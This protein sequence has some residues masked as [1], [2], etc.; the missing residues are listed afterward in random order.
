MK[1]KSLSSGKVHLNIYNFKYLYFNSLKRIRS[2]TTIISY[3]IAIMFLRYLLIICLFFIPEACGPSEDE[4]WQ[5]TKNNNTTEAYEEFLGNFPTSKHTKEIKTI[6]DSL[7]FKYARN[8]NTREAYEEYLVKYPNG[9]FHTE[10]RNKLDQIELMEFNK[11]KQENTKIAFENYLRIYPKGKFSSE[12][13]NCIH[14]Y[15]PTIRVIIKESYKNLNV[16]NLLP[17]VEICKNYLEPL[18]FQISLN[19]NDKIDAVLTVEVEGEP[20]DYDGIYL[21]AKV[22]GKIIYKYS[23]STEKYT[24][25]FHGQ[26]APYS[27]ARYSEMMKKPENAPFKLALIRGDLSRVHE[28]SFYCRLLQLVANVWGTSRLLPLLEDV[29]I[30]TRSVAITTLIYNINHS[31]LPHD[32][33]FINALFDVLRGDYSNYSD[34]FPYNI[35]KNDALSLLGYVGDSSSI[36]DL[37]KLL[38]QHQSDIDPASIRKVIK[39]INYKK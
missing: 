36:K 15:Y 18:G 29:S 26:E 6:L 23:R 11:V 2:F 19:D 12:A 25:F 34:Y 10:V 30:D 7:R 24:V 32:P 31:D 3:N 33:R 39:K 20:I 16:S 35:E 21:G 27:F 22:S 8:S 37:E 4:Q 1:K 14:K 38:S 5:T 28:V 13:L 17:F 9:V